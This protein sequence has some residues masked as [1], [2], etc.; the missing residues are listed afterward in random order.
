MDLDLPQTLRIVHLRNRN[1]P[2]DARMPGLRVASPDDVL[3]LLNQTN[4]GDHVVQ[5]LGRLEKV[6]SA[7]S[8]KTLR[9]EGNFHRTRRLW[10]HEARCLLLSA[11]WHQQQQSKSTNA[12]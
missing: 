11:A 6:I 9:L 8:R 4:A 2:E 5:Q 7:G 3:E 10:W 12:S 1:G